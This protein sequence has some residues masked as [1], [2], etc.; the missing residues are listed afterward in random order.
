MPGQRQDSGPSTAGVGEEVAAMASAELPGR[1]S[2]ALCLHVV[3]PM[4]NTV[5]YP[6]TACGA[7]LITKY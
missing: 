1:P 3:Q 5:L 2:P 6:L 7:K 4:S